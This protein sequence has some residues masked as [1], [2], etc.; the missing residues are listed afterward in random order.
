MEIV[1]TTLIVGGMGLVCAVLLAAVARRFGIKENQHI[2]MV[3]EVLPQANC[4][5]CSYAGCADY[6]K[7]IVE[8]GA[9]LTLCPPGGATVVKKLSALMGVDA[10]AD[11]PMTAL[12]RCGGDLADARRR[13][14]Y[15]GITD[16]IAA[17]AIHGGD[18]ACSFGCLGY[19]AC[20]RVCPVNAM[21][22][23][24]G[25]IRVIKERCIACGSCIKVCPRHLIALVPKKHAIHVLCMSQDKGSLVRRLCARGC[26]GCK[27]CTRLDPAFIMDG[28]LAT[29]DYTR[30]PVVNE[31]VIAKCPEKCI[32]K[33]RN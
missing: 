10:T 15:N 14:D 11:E 8:D 12:V 22:A 16:C 20:K 27:I 3:A 30:A 31:E 7:A 5:A 33:D 2:A 9:L 13:Y 1:I 28:N 25:L 26:I 29:V 4:G 23:E 19:G 21:I 17:H 18:K 6:A 32:H 24:N